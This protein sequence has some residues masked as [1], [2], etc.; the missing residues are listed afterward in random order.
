L[1]R[2]AQADQHSP[3]PWGYYKRQAPIG[4]GGIILCDSIV[5]TCIL[6]K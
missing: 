5:S 3:Q 1:S 2:A 6:V 4:S